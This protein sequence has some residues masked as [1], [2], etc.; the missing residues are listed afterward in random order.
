MTWKQ[1]EVTVASL[2]IKFG[3]SV[4]VLSGYT[5][6]LVL[7]Q[8]NR[9]ID[10]IDLTK[11]TG[12]LTTWAFENV[13]YT[14]SEDETV[15]FTVKANI[16]GGEIANIGKKVQL[17][18][19][20]YNTVAWTEYTIASELPEVV[21]SDREDEFTTITVNN[22]S[23]YDDIEVSSITLKVSTI[24]ENLP[25]N[26][27]SFAA[28][29][30]FV[31]AKNGN[32]ISWTITPASRTVP[33]TITFVPTTPLNN[34]DYLILE[35]ENTQGVEGDWYKVNVSSLTFKYMDDTNGD[36]NYTDDEKTPAITETYDV[37]L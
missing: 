35:L 19:N 22:T 23:S 24:I 13:N 2:D 26:M 34:G 8:W 16:K 31:D 28:T 37:T 5:D 29:A 30:R 15:S 12:D 1:I 17:T 21:L 6:E 11:L 25:K 33:G 3:T 10:T 20:S 32:V 14:I 9:E 36:G 27:E 18:L 7:M 4:N